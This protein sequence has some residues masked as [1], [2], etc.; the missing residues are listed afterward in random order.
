M[1]VTNN[2]TGQNIVTYN[3][4]NLTT[5][6]VFFT[7]VHAKLFH[8]VLD[9]I[10]SQNDADD[11]SP[12]RGFSGFDSAAWA[13]IRPQVIESIVLLYQMRKY[14]PVIAGG[15]LWSWAAMMPAKDVDIFFRNGWL[16]RRRL[17]KLCGHASSENYHY[18]KPSYDGYGHFM[19]V[20]AGLRYAWQLPATKLPVDFVLTNWEGIQVINN[21]DFIYSKVAFGINE[22]ATEGAIACSVGSLEYNSRMCPR[23]KA[24]IQAKMAKNPLWGSPTAVHR[25]EFLIRMLQAI[26]AAVAYNAKKI[27]V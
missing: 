22:F 15:A 8:T 27:S 12:Y 7:F 4:G 11:Q 21:F 1:F 10:T 2:K 25:M 9:E 26:Y 20:I 6:N 23:D 17:L 3:I 19:K 14:N 18:D 24:Y 5:N 13:A 16:R